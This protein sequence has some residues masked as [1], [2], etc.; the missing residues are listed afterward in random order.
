MGTSCPMAPGTGRDGAGD[1]VGGSDPHQG[2]RRRR[3]LRQD[4]PRP[5][6]AP[7]PA[8][9]PPA[10]HRLSPSPRPLRLPH[11]CPHPWPHPRPLHVPRPGPSQPP[12]LSPCAHRPLPPARGDWGGAAPHQPRSPQRRPRHGSTRG[13]GPAPLAGVGMC[14]CPMGRGVGDGGSPCSPRRGPV[15]TAPTCAGW[16]PGQR[17]GPRRGPGGPWPGRG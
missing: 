1:G 13:V 17:R 4:Q 12:V 7:N 2:A 14:R 16:Q 6:P 11:V 10:S 3:M 5:P 8:H 15:A 9:A